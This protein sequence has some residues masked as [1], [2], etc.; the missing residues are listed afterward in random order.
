M[1]VA[2]RGLRHTGQKQQQRK[3]P[4]GCHMREPGLFPGGSALQSPFPGVRSATRGRRNSESCQLDQQ[5]AQHA[6]AHHGPR[7][8]QQN[9]TASTGSHGRPSEEGPKVP[10]WWF[11]KKLSVEMTGLDGNRMDLEEMRLLHRLL[12]RMAE[13]VTVP[14]SNDWRGAGG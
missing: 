3:K 8:R 13:Q 11:C 7:K 10:A 9:L 12:A 4:S 6:D 5:G 14:S 1:T 2:E